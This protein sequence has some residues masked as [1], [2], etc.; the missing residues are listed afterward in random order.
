MRQVHNNIH[1][2]KTF[3]KNYSPPSTVHWQGRSDAP[4]NAYLFQTIQ[5]LNLL[6]PITQPNQPA[7][8]L[9]GFCC[10]EGIRRNHGRL[11][12]ASG[13]AACRDALAKLPSTDRILYDAGDITCIDN[14]LEQAQ[15]ALAEAVNVLLSA[16][17]IPLVIGGGHEVAWGHYQGIAMH[18]A[19]QTL[20]IVNF[21]AHFDMRPLLPR[22]QGSSGTPF[23]Q[24]AK[25]HDE[26]RRRF[27]YHCIGIQP[28]GNMSLLFETAKQYHTHVLSADDIH[29]GHPNSQ[30]DFIQRVI[31]TNDM[32]YVS[33]CLDVIAAP[34]APGVSAPQ[35]MGLLPWTIVPLLRQLA[36][37][38]KVISYDLAELSPPLDKDGRTA[39]LAAAF[40]YEILQHHTIAV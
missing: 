22:Q 1:P 19:T 7:F 34:F 39:R 33:L 4:A 20:G 16:A 29:Q 13:P 10:D 24:I 40:I 14:N 21:D 8:A 18:Q 28:A 25:A 36:Q 6:Q 38:G 5:L 23:L 30:S 37:S 2:M 32:L 9:L 15:Q 17:F 3:S 26:A 35:P 12:A 27:D 31:S 11:G